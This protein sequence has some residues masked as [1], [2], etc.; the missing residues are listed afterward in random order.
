[1]HV[2]ASDVWPSCD[3]IERTR[4]GKCFS[5][6]GKYSAL[7]AVSHVCTQAQDSAPYKARRARAIGIARDAMRRA[8]ARLCSSRAGLLAQGHSAAETASRLRVLA[9]GC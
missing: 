2:F 3:T 5:A 8:T 7:S 4:C 9:R 1:M 6:Q